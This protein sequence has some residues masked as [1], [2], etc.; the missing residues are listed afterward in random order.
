MARSRTDDVTLKI[1]RPLYERLRQV[2]EGTGFHSVTEFCVY[3]L[4]DLVSSQVPA[5]QDDDGLTHE[6]VAAIRRR[7]QALGYLED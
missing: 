1:P 6:E 3:V 2:I 5:R 7:L 4:R